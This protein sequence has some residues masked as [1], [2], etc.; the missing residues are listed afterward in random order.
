MNAAQKNP[1][2]EDFARLAEF[3]PQLLLLAGRIVSREMRSRID[4][5]DVVQETL[6]TASKSVPN[7]DLLKFPIFVWL[8]KLLRQR[9]IDAKRRHIRS[10]KR[11]VRQEQTFSTAE[12]HQQVLD[13]LPAH[14][15][16][17]P[18]S[19]LSAQT[20]LQ[21]LEDALQSLT[22]EAE[23]LLRQRYFESLSLVE[24]AE[25]TGI[26]VSAAKMRHLRAVRELR[27]VLDNT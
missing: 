14:Y 1:T 24:I 13:C 17:R 7:C 20:R 18:P 21:K 5:S 27:K 8:C 26:S 15:Q 22:P 25:R 4:P 6:L 9:V 10:G 16:P 12:T 19:E 11:S 3:R 23:S 2:N